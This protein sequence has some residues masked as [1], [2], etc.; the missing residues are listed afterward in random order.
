MRALRKRPPALCLIATIARGGQDGTTLAAICAAVREVAAPDA[1]TLLIQLRDKEATAA[2]LT[3]AASA[4]C[5]A[6]APQKAFVLMNERADVVVMT[7]AAGVHLGAGSIPVAEAR[8]LLPAGLIG[9]S[10]HSAEE[11]ARVAGEGA[12]YVLLSPVWDSPGKGAALGLDAL[13]RTASACGET[14]VLALGG[15]NGSRAGEALKAGAGGVALIRSVFDAPEPAR[16]A[17][18]IARAMVDPGESHG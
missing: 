3:V 10:A 8:R 16:A 5:E 6:L 11:A 14:P 17:Q 2:S 9:W 18:E 4:W 15:V 1:L 7:G 12:D 13:S